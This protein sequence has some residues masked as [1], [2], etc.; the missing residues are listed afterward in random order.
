MGRLFFWA[1]KF[2]SEE[3]GVTAALLMRE[4]LGSEF[5]LEVWGETDKSVEGQARASVT[6]AGGQGS[7]C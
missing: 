6:I 2:L 7:R 1:A 5:Y 4:I 3:E